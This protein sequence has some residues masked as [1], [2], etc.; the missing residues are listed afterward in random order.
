MCE[1][2]D[3]AEEIGKAGLNVMGHLCR[4]KARARPSRRNANSPIP[5]AIRPN[6]GKI[7]PA[8]RILAHAAM[9]VRRNKELP[10]PDLIVIDESFWRDAVAHMR[11]ALD[12]LTEVEPL[13]RHARASQAAK[14]RRR[15]RSGPPKRFAQVKAA[16]KPTTAS[17]MP[18]FRPSG[19]AVRSRT[20][21]T[22]APS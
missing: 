1:K 11:L 8:I 21:A 4:L 18:S 15:K 19:S 7:G 6:F 20:A 9:F 3:L 10:A 22:R 14:D 12:R 13:A 5:A 2:A 16:K 17:R